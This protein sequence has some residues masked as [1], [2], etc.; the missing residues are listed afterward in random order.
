MKAVTLFLSISILALN[1]YSQTGPHFKKVVWIV[2]E[3]ENYTQVLNQEDFAKFAA[4]GVSFS[5]MMSETH[6]SQGNYV[7]MIAGST[8]GVKDDKNVDLTS[9]HIG[10]LLESNNKDWHVYAEGYPENC[11]IQARAGDYVRKHNPFLSFTNVS[12]NPQ[13]CAKITN[14]KNFFSDFKNNL[15]AEFTMYIPN[16]KNDGHDTSIDFAGM[17]LTKNFG[18]LLSEPEALKDTLFVISF[19]ESDSR[20][21]NNQIYTVFV[22]KNIVKGS[23]NKQLLNHYAILKMIEDEFNLANLGRYDATA[24]KIENIWSN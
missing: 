23:V 24:P 15:L 22:G 16:M 7:A 1:V 14:E 17:W 3:N 6:P 19:D 18:D 2:F 10:D 4:L 5:Q 11:F 8:L 20:A 9:N 21:K 12:R 13:R